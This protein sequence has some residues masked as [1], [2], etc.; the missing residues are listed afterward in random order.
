MVCCVMDSVMI[1]MVDDDRL[2]RQYESLQSLICE[3][4]T[5]ICNLP[6]YV[7]TTLLRTYDN[8]VHHRTELRSD[9]VTAVLTALAHMD[10]RTWSCVRSKPFVI[11]MGDIRSNA[12]M[13]V[14]RP[15][16]DDESDIIYKK[17]WKL[18]T[19]TWDM[20]MLSCCIWLYDHMHVVFAAR[21]LAYVCLELLFWNFVNSELGIGNLLSMST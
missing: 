19:M 20:I 7:I 1:S 14:Q 2:I 15:D 5:W 4:F 13:L 12:E 18:V 11:C 9:I 6:N 10:Y 16:V 8:D 17:I 21:H 3:E